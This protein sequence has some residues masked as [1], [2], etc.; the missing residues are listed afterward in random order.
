MVPMLWFKQE[1]LLPEDLA[2]DAKVIKSNKN[3]NLFYFKNEF[4]LAVLIPDLGLYIAYAFAGIGLV[5]VSTGIFLTVTKRW[6]KAN[7][8]RML[9]NTM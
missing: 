7:S 8:E 3:L 6:G 4:Q 9:T 2:G 1:V 5:L